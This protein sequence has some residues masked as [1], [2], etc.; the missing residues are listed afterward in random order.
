MKENHIDEVDMGDHSETV[1]ACVPPLTVV[2][3]PLGRMTV[4]VC[5]LGIVKINSI[6]PFVYLHS[7]EIVPSSERKLPL[8][9]PSLLSVYGRMVILPFDTVIPRTLLIIQPATAPKA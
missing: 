2:F 8:A 7:E 1:K 5:P 9:Y 6:L 3:S 4:A